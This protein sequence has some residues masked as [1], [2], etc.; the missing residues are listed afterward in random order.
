MEGWVTW[1]PVNLSL[2]PLKAKC[3]DSAKQT[4]MMRPVEPLTVLFCCFLCVNALPLPD[5]NSHKHRPAADWP[6][7]THHH[8]LKKR[9]RLHHAQDSLSEDSGDKRVHPHTQF[10]NRPRCGVPDYPLQKGGSALHYSTH[11]GG[12]LAGRHR[13]KRFDLFPGRWDKTDLTYKIIRVPRQMDWENVR[14]VIK[15]ALGVWSEETPLKFTEVTSGRADIMFDFNRYSHGDY[16]D[17]DGPGGILAHAFFPRTYREG[18]VHFDMDESWTIGNSLGTDLLQVATH[19]IGHV[20][21]LQHSKVLGAVMA[22]FYTFSYPVRLSDDDKRGIQALYGSRRIDDRVQTEERDTTIKERNE[23]DT[24]LFPPFNPDPSLPDA[25]QTNFDAVS[26]IRGELFFFKSGYVWRIRDG[27]LQAGYPALASRHWRGIPDKID[28]A[29]EDKSGNI[30]FFQGQNYWVFDAERQITGPDSVRRLGLAVS[31]IQAALMWGDNKAQKIYF[32]KKGSYWR[33]N[34]RENRVESMH[35]RSMSDW[36]GIPS[37]ID[38]A[39]QDRFGFAHF[40]RGKQYWKF[41][42]VEVRVLEGYPRYIG[43]DFF[44]CSASLYR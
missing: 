6:Q 18:E 30:W 26:M 40:L 15:E 28:A 36:R 9:G 1:L 13:R 33:F 44:G 29:F 16:L 17:F 42:P 37:D 19:E 22:P 32:F 21:G 34:Q 8:G 27:K 10:W 41:D 12:L 24:T 31:D 39:F 11:K 5:P 20:L 23:I 25:C 4:G 3:W 7:K 35:P 14:T 2:Q 38:A 43:M